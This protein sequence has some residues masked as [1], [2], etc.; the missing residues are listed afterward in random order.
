MN[1][2][3]NIYNYIIIFLLTIYNLVYH[4][5]ILKLFKNEEAIITSVFLILLF[6][7]SV[8]MYGFT[9]A[10]LNPFKKK[11]V[12]KVG[13]IVV[14][15]IGVTY[16]IGAFVG[17]LR[18]GYS[19]ALINIIKN[20][21]TPIFIAVF[22]EMFRY[23]IIRAN[24]N[25]FKMIILFTALLTILELQM[26][27]AAVLSWG[28]REIFIVVTTLII[29]VIAK[30][31]VLSYLSY[32]VGYKPCLIYR[33]ILELY[34]YFVPYLPK[35]GDYLNSMF[36]LILPMIIFIYTSQDEEEAKGMVQ[37]EFQEKKSKLVKIPI[38]I[39]IFTVIALISRVFPI[40]MIGI[41]SESMT[42]AINKGDAVIA[43]KVK[44]ENIQENDVIVFQT[45]D[46]VLIHR[47]VEIEN[48][49]GVNHYRT[50]GDANGTRDNIDI[51]MD[52]IYG[53]VKLRIPCIAYPS[54]YLTEFM[55]KHK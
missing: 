47:V 33:L 52:K 53:E 31:M 2:K 9:K 29:P 34:I 43:I 36:G 49:D 46:K 38:Y 41:G 13:I 6:I 11:T 32:E 3:Q 45:Q 4:F 51:T 35:F 24:K 7:A 10:K 17:F 40:F 1:N 55:Q 44:E 18:N 19:L 5:V 14:L 50:K 42:G 25:K 22:T 27:T 16:C 28:L 21:F 54:V 30:N 8:I 20:T 26:N 39:L 48:I 23:N 15:S 12:R 37:P